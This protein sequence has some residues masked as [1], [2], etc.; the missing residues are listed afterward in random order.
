DAV[1]RNGAAELIEGEFPALCQ[2]SQSTDAIDGGCVGSGDRRG[3]VHVAQRIAVL[4][5]G[6]GG[7]SRN[8]GDDG[9]APLGLAGLLGG[10]KE[11][12]FIVAVVDLGNVDGPAESESIIVTALVRTSVLTGVTVRHARDGVGTVAGIALIAVGGPRIR[13]RDSGI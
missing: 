4:V 13:V 1:L 2:V 3:H 10:E 6:A 5:E 8:G 11:E 7:Q 12:S 9:G